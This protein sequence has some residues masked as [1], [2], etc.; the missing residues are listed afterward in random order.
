MLSKTF[1]L[2]NE[3]NNFVKASLKVFK[4]LIYREIFINV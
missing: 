4:K 3:K 2:F 1:Q